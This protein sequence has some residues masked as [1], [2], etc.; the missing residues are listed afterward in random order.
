MRAA[1]PADV[2]GHYRRIVLAVKAHH[3]QEATRQLMPHLAE[4][5][6]VLSAQNGLNELVIAGL[7]GERRTM[8]CFVNFGADYLGP[9]RII[10]GN[11]AAVVVGELDGAMTDRVREMHAL[12][13]ELE[14]DAVLTDDIFAY[15][16]GQ[17]RLRR[18]AVRHG[19]D[20]RIDRGRA[21]LA[22]PPAGVPGSRQRGH[23][24]GPGEG[25]EA[26]GLQTAST[27]RPSP[28]AVIRRRCRPPSTPW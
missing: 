27:R 23:G 14:P 5:G 25:R 28:R 12:L 22:P 11:R 6:Y 15:L 17:A 2:T 9:G 19:A 8:G 16:W 21:R 26:D 7:V 20:E 3:T 1:L 10:R 18:A 4:D 24:G 13:R